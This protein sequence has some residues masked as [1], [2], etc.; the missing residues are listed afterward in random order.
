[1]G[2]LGG[3]PDLQTILPGPALNCNPLDLSFSSR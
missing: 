1:L 2:G 3:M